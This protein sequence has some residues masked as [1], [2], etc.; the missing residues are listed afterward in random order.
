MIRKALAIVAPQVGV[1]KD[2][3]MKGAT[4]LPKALTAEKKAHQPS[5]GP[6]SSQ[7]SL[8]KAETTQQMIYV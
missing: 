7:L 8:N 5:Y 4:A 6:L 2:C 3:T 1:V